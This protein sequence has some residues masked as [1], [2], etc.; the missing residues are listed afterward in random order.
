MTEYGKL[1]PGTPGGNG[2]L[3]NFL[4]QMRIVEAFQP[5][6]LGNKT[7]RRHAGQG[8]DLKAPCAALSVEDEVGTGVNGQA[9]RTVELQRRFRH[10][11]PI[12]FTYSCRAYL[13]RTLAAALVFG[14]IVEARAFRGNDLNRAESPVAKDGYGD[15][16]T[17]DFFFDDD[18]V[19][20]FEHAAQGGL[21]L[22]TRIW[23]FYAD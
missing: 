3:D 11:L 20:V 2:K 9:E 5:G 18:A 13:A 4:A 19:A 6:G 22:R 12:L 7:V 15:L 8:I 23:K 14:D 16:D 17:R 21:Q 1:L 10:G